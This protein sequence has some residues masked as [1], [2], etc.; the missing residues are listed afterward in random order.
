MVDGADGVGQ[1]GRVAVGGAVDERPHPDPLGRHG[2]GRVGRDRLVAVVPDV[3]RGVEVVPDR[4][5]VEAEALDLA[6]QVDELLRGGVLETGV[7]PEPRHGAP[8]GRHH[9]PAGGSGLSRMMATSS[10][11]TGRTIDDCHGSY[12]LVVANQPPTAKT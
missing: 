7:D 11:K 2:Q 1:H 8:F 6:P 12:Q 4:D 3:V 9:A 5:P 10:T